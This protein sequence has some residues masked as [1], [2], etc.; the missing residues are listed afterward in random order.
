MNKDFIYD[1]IVRKFYELETYVRTAIKGI[2]NGTSD[3]HDALVHFKC[4]L[5][6]FGQDFAYIKEAL[7]SAG[8]SPF[9][10]F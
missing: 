1:G 4:L 2:E 9:E 7:S 5:A 10:T 6:R 3:I 8:F